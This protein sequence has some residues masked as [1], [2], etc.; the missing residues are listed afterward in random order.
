MAVNQSYIGSITNPI[1]AARLEASL[2]ANALARRVGVSRQY[3]SRAEGGT[4]SS[5]NPALL[6]WVAS[7]S[8]IHPDAI[9]Q[10]YVIFQKARRRDTIE[11]LQ[12][13]QLT[14]NGNKLDP[15]NVIFERWRSGYW[16]SVV[17]FANDFCVHPDL[18]TKY[19]E[20]IQKSM[21]KQLLNALKETHLI[22]SDWIDEFWPQ[23]Q[24][25]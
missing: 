19:E 11:R 17:A 14:R 12:P 16:P 20:G 25:P 6:K 8:N 24:K 9:M 1:V 23:G 10:R 5:L 2:S 15:G 4:Y 3:L 18:V 13:H 21:P 7:A 22:E